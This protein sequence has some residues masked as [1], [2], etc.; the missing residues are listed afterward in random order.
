MECETNSEGELRADVPWKMG[1]R[2]V[3]VTSQ[4]KKINP[5]TLEPK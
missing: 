5:L 3:S 4:K 2:T 1:E